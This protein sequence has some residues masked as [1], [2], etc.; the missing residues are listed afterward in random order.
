MCG[1]AGGA[2][3]DPAA[4]GDAARAGLMA[5]RLGHRG[6]D[7]RGVRSFAGCALAHTRLAIID[8]SPRGAQPMTHEDESLW[9]VFN[10][11]IYNYLELRRELAPRHEFRS[12]SDTEVILHLYE[13]RGAAAVESLRGM[14]AFALWDIRERRLLLARDRLGKKPLYYRIREDG[15]DFAS[16]IPALL[17]AGGER[18]FAAETLGPYLCLGYVPA[19][20]TGL[21][22]IQRLPAASTLVWERGRAALSRYWSPPLP[23]GGDS[24]GED[25]PAAARR[26]LPLLEESVRIRLRSDVPVGVFL[27]GGIDSAVVAALAARAA[28]APIR[29][30]TVVFDEAGYDE[31]AAARATASAIGSIHH[32]IHV[33][34][35]A[36]E[37]LPRLVR[38]SGDLFADSSLV[39]VHALSKAVSAEVKVALSGDGGD[40]VF[41]GYDRYRAHRLASRFGLLPAMA[42]EAAAAS[43]AALP[44]ARSRRNLAGRAARFF[45]AASEDPF[46][47]NDR[48][49]SR[50]HAA[51]ISGM[52]SPEAAALQ[53]ADPLGQLHD[54]YREGSGLDPLDAIARADLALW[55]PE[56]VLRKVD[57]ASMA[58]G[59]EV[60]SPLLDHRLVEEAASLP[61]RVR[62]PRGRTKEILR[63]CARN[64]LP[65]RTR[66]ARKAGFGLP[67]DR[68]L[69]GGDLRELAHDALDP[70]ASA[71]RSLFAAGTAAR[72]LREHESGEANHDEAIWTMIVLEVFLREVV[73]AAA[74]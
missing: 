65:A 15:I 18:S 33:E 68:W 3:S 66:R 53:P 28:A 22:G 40:E 23:G 52:L 69:R 61:A 26:I 73:G 14:F 25:T 64:L 50:F 59:L 70:P 39:A 10:G 16:E 57:T 44:G 74:R 27:S 19:P 54:L 21:R 31:S 37:I 9:V 2:S 34:A 4:P 51:A 1:I 56:D 38:G 29:T 13:E 45:E 72:L 36:A 43:A 12:G 24:P 48:W 60:R 41:L 11:E 30:F 63:I 46:E 8:L 20:A 62:M 6:P 49:V 67:L 17:E 5:G 32:E 71:S 42:R 55:L 47:R 35:R 7:G 58:C